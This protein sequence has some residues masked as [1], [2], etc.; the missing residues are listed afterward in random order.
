[1]ESRLRMQTVIDVGFLCLLLVLMMVPTSLSAAHETDYPLPSSA[2]RC[3]RSPTPK[4][5]PSCRRAQNLKKWL[6]PTWP[7]FRWTMPHRPKRIKFSRIQWRN[8]CLRQRRRF[9]SKRSQPRWSYRRLRSRR[10]LPRLNASA[11]KN[12]NRQVALNSAGF[13]VVFWIFLC[14][15]VTF[16]IRRLSPCA[17]TLVNLVIST[18]L[19]RG[20]RFDGTAVGLFF[21]RSLIWFGVEV[22]ACINF[23]FGGEPPVKLALTQQSAVYN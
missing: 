20:G 13:G 22:V 8:R 9:R 14:N 21:F 3:A 10:T 23:V 12:G 1:M 19:G 16:R 2:L 17:Q 18:R 7:P 5:G 4:H 11:K 15:R 6:W